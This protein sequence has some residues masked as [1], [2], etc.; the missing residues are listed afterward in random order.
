M[1]RNGIIQ[2]RKAAEM[3][4]IIALIKGLVIAGLTTVILLLVLA[5]VMLQMQPDLKTAEMGILIIYVL[6]VFAGGWFCG[7]KAG[8]RKF[9]WGMVTGVSYFLLLVTVS[10]MGERVLQS[11]MTE[12]ITAFLICVAGGTVGGMLA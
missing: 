4:R 11:G 3:N 7:K 12:G 10:V 2:E 5:F 6:S 8:N 1:Y 9:L